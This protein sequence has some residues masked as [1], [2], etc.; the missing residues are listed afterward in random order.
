MVTQNPQLWQAPSWTV[1]SQ[2]SR[3]P[4]EVQKPSHHLFP[5]A[6]PSQPVERM[7][8]GGILIGR[9]T[10]TPGSTQSSKSQSSVIWSPLPEG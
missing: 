4:R 7:L 5:G 9:E 3:G 2:G 6:G 10:N 1:L 8:L